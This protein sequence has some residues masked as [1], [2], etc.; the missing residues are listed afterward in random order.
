ME[1]LVQPSHVVPDLG[2]LVHQGHSKLDNI[3]SCLQV[4]ILIVVV[5]LDDVVLDDSEQQRQV[6][7]AEREVALQFLLEWESFEES[8]ESVLLD[9]FVVRA[10]VV[11]GPHNSNLIQQRSHLRMLEIYLWCCGQRIE[12]NLCDKPTEVAD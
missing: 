7:C 6:R 4:V 9:R 3:T 11:I 1:V 5:V 12:D 2:V 8:R 10:I